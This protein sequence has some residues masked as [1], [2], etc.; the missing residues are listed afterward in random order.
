MGRRKEVVKVFCPVQCWLLFHRAMWEAQVGV[1]MG[2]KLSQCCSSRDMARL[3]KCRAFY[4]QQL[5][6]TI[7]KQHS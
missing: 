6:E 7:S 4:L 2:P 1:G 3:Q 5:E